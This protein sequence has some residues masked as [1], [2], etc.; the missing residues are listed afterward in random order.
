[1]K[2]SNCS[3]EDCDYPSTKMFPEPETG[4]EYPMCEGHYKFMNGEKE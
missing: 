1:M 2:T 3:F 4:K